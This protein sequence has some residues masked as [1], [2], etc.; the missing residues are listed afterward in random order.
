MTNCR[1]KIGAL[2]AENTKLRRQM[3][4]EKMKWEGELMKGEQLERELREL[5][6]VRGVFLRGWKASGMSWLK[7]SVP[8]TVPGCVVRFAQL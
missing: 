8:S 3:V 4:E 1:D 2:S 6:E 7:L 5:P